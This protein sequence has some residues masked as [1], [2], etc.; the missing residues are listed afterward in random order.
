MLFPFVVAAKYN[1]GIHHH[2]FF[3]AAK[4]HTKSYVICFVGLYLLVSSQQFSLQQNGFI[5]SIR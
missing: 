4:Q 2:H 1:T 5:K 3:T